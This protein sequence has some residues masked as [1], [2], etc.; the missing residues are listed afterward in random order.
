MFSAGLFDIAV[1]VSLAALLGLLAKTLKQPLVLAYLTTGVIIAYLGVFKS[2]NMETFRIFSDLGIML[3]LFLVGLEINYSSL[4]LIGK[5]ALTVGIGQILLTFAFGLLIGLAF[6]FPLSQAAFIAIAL[7]FS[8]TAIV[9]KFLSEKG[10]LR[11]L[12][13]RISVGILLIQDVAVIALLVALPGFSASGG[14]GFYDAAANAAKG[15]T[16]IAVILLIGQSVLPAILNKISRNQ[17]LLFLFSLSWVFLI[18]IFMEAVGFS[19][20]IGGFIAGLALAGS[21]QSFE[22]GGRIKPLR[23]F[24]IVIFFIILGS[25]LVFSGAKTLLIPLAAFSLLVLLGGPLI[26]ILLMGFLRYK[27]RTSFLTGVT[28]SQVS[29]F[30]FILAALGLRLGQISEG[31]A[32]LITTVGI[33]TITVSTYVILHAESIFRRLSPVLSRFERRRAKNENDTTIFQKPIVLIGCHRMGQS[34]AFGLPK[35]KVLVV[36]CDMDIVKDLSRHGFDCLFGDIA[37]PEIYSHAGIGNA[38]MVISTS[39]HLHDNLALISYIKNGGYQPKII[40]RAEDGNDAETLYKKGADYV[41]L[42]HLTAGQYL[43]RTIALHPEMDV[44]E[45]LRNQDLALQKKFLKK[46]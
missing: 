9:V 45:R 10:D 31:A 17:E 14:F 29:E 27:K 38:Q 22:I 40:A 41:I 46:V 7:T 34:I 3:L 2:G 28:I 16:G 4:R 39:P 33:T 35:E 8:S 42:P 43:G 20:A 30:S 19:L 25:S 36:D 12:Y 24:F 32:A 1:L 11:T 18:A 15:L 26:V 5:T 13:G 44:L 6:N 37:D 23:D 21:A